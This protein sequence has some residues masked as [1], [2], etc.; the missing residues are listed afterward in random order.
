M[1]ALDLYR[2]EY[3]EACVRCFENRLAQYRSRFN[4]AGIRII[5]CRQDIVLLTLALVCWLATA[6]DRCW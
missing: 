2:R 3:N 6:T 4:L 1:A 5:D